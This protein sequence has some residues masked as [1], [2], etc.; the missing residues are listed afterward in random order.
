MSGLLP[1]STI[2]KARSDI[3]STVSK[4]VELTKKGSEFTAC[5]PFHSERT[6][7]FSVVPDKSMFYCF[8]CGASGD[9][10]DFVQNF[11]NVSFREAVKRIVGDLPAGEVVPIKSVRKEEKPEW[12]PVVPVP[13]ETKLLPMDI[14]NRRKGSEWE[15]LVASK[16]WPYLNAKG[17]L[18]GY[19]CRFELPGGGKDV[20]PQSF[21]VN[22]TTGEMSWRWLSFEKPRPIYGLDLLAANPNAQVLVVEGEKACDAARELLKAAGVPQD[23]LLAVSWPGGGKAVAHT[24]WSPLAGRAVALWPDADQKPYPEKHRHAG[25]L[26][27]FVFQPGSLCMFA[28][29]ENLEGVAKS[30]KF[31]IPPEGVADGWDL[32]DDLPDG[33][34][35]LAHMKAAALTMDQLWERYPETEAAEVEAVAEA[36][37][38]ADKLPV[39]PSGESFE[40][41]PP[42]EGD[43]SIPQPTYAKDSSDELDTLI[44]NSYFTVLGY[45]Q[46]TYYVFHHEKMQVISLTKGDLSDIGLIEL[47]PANWW[48]E[49]F[50]GSNGIDRKAAANW[51]FRLANS[52]GIYDPTRVRGRGAWRD[53]GRHVFHHGG[54]LTVDGQVCGITGIKSKF[55]YPL[56][57]SLPEP[58]LPL[59]DDEGRNL[60]RVATMVRWSKPASGPLMAGWVMLASICGSLG[61]RP[62]IWLTGAAGSGKSTI[63]S[64]YIAALLGGVALYAQGNSTEAGI[65]QELSSDARP[66]LMDELE[67]NTEVERRK[68]EALLSLIR[69]A[70]T[71]SPAKTLKGTMGGTAQ[72]FHVRS[73]FCLASVNTAIDK[74]ADIDRLTKLVIRPPA[75]ATDAEEQWVKLRDE[76]HK[77]KTDETLPSRL[78]ARALSML[79]IIHE[80]IAVFT[81][82]AAKFF[83]TQRDGD[84]FG[85][86]LAGCWCLVHN[87]VA[88]AEEADKMIRFYDW[89][90]HTEDH[91]QDDAQ[92][93]LAV[94][95]GSKLRVG[96]IGEL[97]VF[98]LIR[99]C[100][101]VHRENVC[102][103]LVAESTLNRHGI[104]IDFLAGVLL[105]G[106]SVPNL[107]ALVEK[108]DFV[109]DL[110][111]QLLRVK[112]ATRIDKSVRFFGSVSKAVGIPIASILGDGHLP[113][114][115]SPL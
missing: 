52:R 100:S 3:V 1:V 92:R 67:S 7:S 44:K 97:S 37:A 4:Y 60:L 81:H 95:L 80:N 68:V 77:I 54:Y 105:L 61:W 33:F 47:A 32:A 28:I 6:P 107:K 112:G 19:I 99:E 98:E 108:M 84:Q 75:N 102:D 63:Q 8:G 48:E 23:K 74:K 70:S 78:L 89:N 56:A 103:H 115:E 64:D 86:L 42:W 15:R 36:P 79:P 5:C 106:T 55:V 21:C 76:L 14:F 43:E 27:P 111:G 30:L 66:V 38:P 11:E 53:A 51:L 59:S 24:D 22:T 12:V 94:L 114:D 85:T 72:N 2:D 45:D 65:R 10:V 113:E 110:R 9:A 20:I 40:E 35:L 71:E 73:M 88:S 46:G 90:E 104:R 49:H 13:A 57:R 69:Q 39:E 96:N 16:R 50:P 83:G 41:L 109:T 93:A 34:S 18:I 62:H 91:D 17:E 25:E 31:V 29:A 87:H 101:P 58:D 26:M 82:V